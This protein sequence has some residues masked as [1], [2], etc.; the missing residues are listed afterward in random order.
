[1]HQRIHV[2]HVIQSK[3]KI[4]SLHKL[5]MKTANKIQTEVKKNPAT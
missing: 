2:V 3:W 1:M 5:S 4:T